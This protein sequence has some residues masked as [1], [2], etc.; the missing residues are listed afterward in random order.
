M[1]CFKRI[2]LKYFSIVFLMVIGMYSD[3]VYVQTVKDKEK[4]R[5]GSGDNEQYKMCYPA[6][7]YITTLEYL[8]SKELFVVDPKMQHS[9]ALEVSNGCI[10]AAQKFLK[11]AGVLLAAEL[12]AQSATKEALKFVKRDEKVVNAFIDIFKM[13]FQKKFLDLSVVDSLTITRELVDSEKVDGNLVA[14]NFQK[15]AEFCLKNYSPSYRDCSRLA[16]DVALVA[17]KYQKDAYQSF[18]RMVEFFSKRDGVNMVASEMFSYALKVVA[19]GP[20]ASESFIRAYDY[21]T[22]SEGLKMDRQNGLQF[23]LE[24]SK[25]STIFL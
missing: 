14:S 20:T 23:A 10:N 7:E 15:T 4:T 9:I 19:L 16:K 13:L 18:I 12:D 6:K 3:I 11:I 1:L 21:A 24:I 8:R 5:V 17:N 2:S 22:S 25:S